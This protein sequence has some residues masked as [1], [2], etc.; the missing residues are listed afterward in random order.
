MK[1]RFLYQNILEA[2][3]PEKENGPCMSRADRA[4]QFMPFAALRGFEAAVDARQQPW[5]VLPIPSEDQEAELEAQLHVLS[6][7]LQAD[8]QPAV[9]LVYFAPRATAQSMLPPH[10]RETIDTDSGRFERLQGNLE[11]IDE[12]LG[13]LRVNGQWIKLAYLLDLQPVMQQSCD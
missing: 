3:P 9:D 4:K 7:R 10:L 2:S 12:Q 5:D 11:R 6:E 1:A 8:Q 13:R